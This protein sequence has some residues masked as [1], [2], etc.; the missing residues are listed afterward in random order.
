MCGKQTAARRSAVIE[1]VRKLETEKENGNETARYIHTYIERETEIVTNLIIVDETD[2]GKT[3][4]GDGDG[5]KDRGRE[6][7]REKDRKIYT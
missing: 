6:R 3:F 1:T 2:G 5:E 4:G 7:G